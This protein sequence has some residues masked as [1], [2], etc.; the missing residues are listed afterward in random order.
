MKG[1][2]LLPA[3][4]PE[5]MQ[6]AL[7]FGADAVYLS[8]KR[9]GMRAAANNFLMQFQADASNTKI[10]RPAC[11]EATA[12]GAAFLAGLATGFWKDKSE[13]LSIPNSVTEFLPSISEFKRNELLNGWKT[14]VR[15]T[16][17]KSVTPN[18]TFSGE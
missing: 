3:G 18:K 11:A 7:R 8:G 15:V 16:K 12:L 2:L 14:A 1:E 6:A 5:K 9:F 13:I 10:I 17:V 4:N